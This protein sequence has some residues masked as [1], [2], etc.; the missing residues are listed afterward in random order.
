MS[1]SLTT[2]L[3]IANA[4]AAAMREKR[5]GLGEVCRSVASVI[6]EHTRRDLLISK[7]ADLAPRL[8][9]AVARFDPTYDRAGSADETKAYNSVLTWIPARALLPDDEITVMLAL[10][11]ADAP[12]PGFHDGDEW[13]RGD[14]SYIP[15]GQVYAWAEVPEMPKEEP[16]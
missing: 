2:E 8:R 3:T 16:R 10:R 11:G 7:I 12:I 14:G 13:R 1:A 4:R 9:A 6:E 5:N 15:D